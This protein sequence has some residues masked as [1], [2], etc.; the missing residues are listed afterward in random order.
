MLREVRDLKGQRGTFLLFSR[1][2]HGSKLR[3]EFWHQ[4]RLHNHKD[5]IIIQILGLLGYS[6]DH[7]NI[8]MG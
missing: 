8:I 2:R 1:S 3:E 4:A 6:S 7:V 5:Q